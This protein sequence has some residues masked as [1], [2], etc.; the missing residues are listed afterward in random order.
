MNQIRERLKNLGKT[1]VWLISKLR[2]REIVVQPPELS[3]VIS[4]SLTTPKAILVRE[5][6]CKILDS[7]EKEGTM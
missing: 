6:I 2:E 1:Q 3:A 7:C 4:G 5:E